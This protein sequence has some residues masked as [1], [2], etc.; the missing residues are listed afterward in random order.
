MKDKVSENSEHNDLIGWS[1][2]LRNNC[3][4]VVGWWGAGGWVIEL[5][6]WRDK[7]TLGRKPGFLLPRKGSDFKIA[8]KFCSKREC[9]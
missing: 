9:S 6:L 5:R 1:W 4:E 8:L 2:R 3:R 7:A